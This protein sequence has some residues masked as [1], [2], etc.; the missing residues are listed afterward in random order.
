MAE[1]QK[2]LNLPKIARSLKVFAITFS[3]SIKIED[4]SQNLEN[5]TFF[6]SHK[7]VVLNTLGVQ[8]LHSVAHWENVKATITQHWRYSSENLPCADH[9]EVAE[10]HIL[11]KITE[12]NTF[13][14]T[15]DL[16]IGKM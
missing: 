11:I 3:I 9:Q 6:K 14:V 1:I 4:G 10:Q 2:I 7:R 5:S 13:E 12:L 15:I 8:N 16:P